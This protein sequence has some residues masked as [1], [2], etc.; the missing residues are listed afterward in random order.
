[1]HKQGLVGDFISRELMY[2][3]ATVTALRACD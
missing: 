3:L 1:V 2:C